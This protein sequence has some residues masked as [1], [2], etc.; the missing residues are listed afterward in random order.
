MLKMGCVQVDITPSYCVYLRGYAG[1]NAL[2][3]GVEEKIFCGVMALEQNGKRVLILTCDHLGIPVGECRIIRQR[4]LQHYPFLREE[5]IFISASH[6]HFAPGFG[7]YI[8][9]KNGGELPVGVYREKEEYF[10][11]FME[12]VLCAAGKAFGELEEVRLL[13]TEQTV[14]SI[15]FN[16]RTPAKTDGKVTTNYRYPE[17]P[18]NW[19]FMPYD[20][21]LHVW[22]FMKKDGKPKAVLVRYGC[23]PVTGGKSPYGI[24]ADYVGYFRDAITRELGCP[25]FF[26]LGTA[27]D[28]VPLTRGG[29]ARRYIGETLANAVLLG[30]LTFRDTTN[31]PLKTAIHTLEGVVPCMDGATAQEL[32]KEWE[33]VLADYRV[34]EYDAKFFL[35]SLKYTFYQEFGAV[36][37]IP[38]PVHTF[39]LGDR[40]LAGLPFEV[41][42]GVGE[43]IR[44]RIPDA[45]V[46]SLCGGYEGYLPVEADFSK[47]GYETDEG[48]VFARDTGDRLAAFAAEKLAEIRKI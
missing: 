40:A 31:F 16:R 28:V 8:I 12:K 26:M 3:K 43:E 22:K 29:S 1:R 20:P 34:K 5:D 45:V 48:T 44:K 19:D 23:H 35:A 21:T 25:A 15:A 33:K 9:Y 42:T 13:Q 6:T 36:S 4:L 14:R 47:G 17:D 46:V 39:Q 38:L 32:E 24:S 7:S 2:S 27:G 18:E 30:E 41:L 37:R 11:F 10:S